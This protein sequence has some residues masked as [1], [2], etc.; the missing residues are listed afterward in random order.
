M[1]TFYARVKVKL[2][3]LFGVIPLQ[4]NFLAEMVL[5]GL[6]EHSSAAVLCQAGALICNLGCSSLPP[7]S[8]RSCKVSSQFS[9]KSTYLVK[10]LENILGVIVCINTSLA[11]QKYVTQPVSPAA[12]KWFMLRVALGLECFHYVF[13]FLCNV[14]TKCR[15]ERL[16]FGC[17]LNDLSWIQNPVRCGTCS[18][19]VWGEKMAPE[20]VGSSNWEP[21]AW[22]SLAPG[23]ARAMLRSPP[24]VQVLVTSSRF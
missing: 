7:K 5:K 2:L 23:L 17:F 1:N 16:E 13:L 15:Q 21:G 8:G 4:D 19:Q 9:A 6:A 20:F 24:C 11:G 3:W 14:L 12:L 22:A 18:K 10:M